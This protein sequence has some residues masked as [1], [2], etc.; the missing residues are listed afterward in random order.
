[1]RGDVPADLC[2]EA[3]TRLLPQ[4]YE[5]LERLYDDGPLAIEELQARLTAELSQIAIRERLWLL[6][7]LDRMVEGQDQLIDHSAT[8]EKWGRPA[9]IDDSER[10]RIPDD[11]Q[12]LQRRIEDERIRRSL[13]LGFDRQTV[14]ERFDVCPR[15]TRYKE[16]R[17][18]AY[19]FPLDA[20]DSE[21]TGTSESRPSP[22]QQS[23]ITDS[24]T[25]RDIGGSGQ[26]ADRSSENTADGPSETPEET[27]MQ[28]AAEAADDH[29]GAEDSVARNNISDD[30]A[31]TS[32]DTEHRDRPDQDEIEQGVAV[33]SDDDADSHRLL[34][35]V[36]LDGV[37]KDALM[38]YC[39][40]Q[41]QPLSGML[42]EWVQ[43]FAEGLAD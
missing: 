39:A 14:A 43:T 33:L 6:M 42:K 41:Q 25:S 29:D 22:S 17:A 10:G 13:D 40:E 35:T 28:P 21:V 11:N 3:V 23:E 15:T 32:V 38:R 26:A 7:G 31:P 16:R 18:R 36:G 27:P 37:E 20:V 8:S 1:V 34:L 4:D 12:T 24:E 2:D 19:A 9:D 30:T 5:I